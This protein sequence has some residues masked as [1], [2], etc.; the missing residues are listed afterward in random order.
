MRSSTRNIFDRER[1]AFGCLPVTDGTRL[2]YLCFHSV[3]RPVHHSEGPRCALWIHTTVLG[4]RWHVDTE[5]SRADGMTRLSGRK[6]KTQASHLTVVRQ[7]AYAPLTHHAPHAWQKRAA[8]SHRK[9][10]RSPETVLTG[11]KGGVCRLS[12]AKNQTIS[13]TLEGPF[14]RPRASQ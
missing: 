6:A 1:D 11:K 12:S 4:V 14:Q 13:S 9:Y 2:V 7:C 8:P 3:R 5:T 10:G